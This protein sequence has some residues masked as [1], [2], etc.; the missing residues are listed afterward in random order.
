MRGWMAA[1][2]LGGALLSACSGDD[3]EAGQRGGP[4]R[5]TLPQCDGALVCTATGCQPAIEEEPPDHT[6]AFDFLVNDRRV[7]SLQLPADGRAQA[8]VR[9]RIAAAQTGEP[10]DTT[11]RV[12][13]VP[14]T[15]GRV[16]DPQLTVAEGS[17]VTT[18]TACD[19]RDPAC[20]MEAILAVADL[21]TPLR[22]I[23]FA[24]FTL[25]RSPPMPDGGANDDQGPRPAQDAGTD[26]RP[27]D[28]G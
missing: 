9:V 28:A 8:L 25:V 18:L 4:C 14:E 5:V 12:F 1:G 6:A 15:A 27:P 2:L 22:A 7:Q 13:L 24:P 23:G 3:P 26:G 20:P 10:V 11:L 16:A 19:A 17:G 21:S